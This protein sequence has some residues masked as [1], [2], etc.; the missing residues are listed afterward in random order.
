MN[1]WAMI[2]KAY[3]KSTKTKLFI[4]VFLNENTLG[5]LT[6]LFA[7]IIFFLGAYF[8]F[9][10]KNSYGF[11]PLIIGEFY[12][13]HKLDKSRKLLIL[14]EYGDLNSSQ[15]PHD[16]KD[17]KRSRY[18]MFKKSLQDGFISKSHVEDCFDLIDIQI[19]IASSSSVN[20]KR[21]GG[22]CFGILIGILAS[23]W[24][25]LSAEELIWVGASLIVMGLLIAFVLF[26]FPSKM[27]NLKEMKY[28]MK[29]YTNEI[30]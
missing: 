15:I 6:I 24:R 16:D 29:L 19:D 11:I 27:E 1:Y 17:H 12:L 9:F 22:F 3:D 23:Y 7:T 8:Q 25:T 28:F 14:N 13:I 5:R 2:W 21:F 18:L 30:Q 26:L 10:E 20:V 4:E